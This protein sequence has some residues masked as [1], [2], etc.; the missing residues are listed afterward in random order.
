VLQCIL[1]AHLVHLFA[2]ENT[3]QYNGQ[4]VFAAD[5]VFSRTAGFLRLR[6]LDGLH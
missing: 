3:W 5:F 2:G 4:H 1:P 6:S